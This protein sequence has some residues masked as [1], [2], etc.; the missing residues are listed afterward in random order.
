MKLKQKTRN[1]LDR[2]LKSLT[3][4]QPKSQPSSG[5]ERHPHMHP[6]V[7]KTHY[8]GH[9]I[10]ITTQYEITMDGKPFPVSVMVGNDGQ[11]HCHGLPNYGFRSIVDMLRQIIDSFSQDMPS[12]E[13]EQTNA[14]RKKSTRGKTKKK[15]KKKPVSRKKTAK[16]RTRRA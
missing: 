10:K 13:L 12:D 14:T 16:T 15:L 5:A 4:K 8:R 11:V 7:R 9:D 6:T 2:E 3:A 1:K